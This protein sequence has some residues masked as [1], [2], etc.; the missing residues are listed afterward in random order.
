MNKNDIIIKS[1]N[2]SVIDRK[3]AMIHGE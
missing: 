1:K 3:T 2:N